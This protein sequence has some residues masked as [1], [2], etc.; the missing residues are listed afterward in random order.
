MSSTKEFTQK[1]RALNKTFNDQLKVL[2]TSYND[3]HKQ[4]LKDFTEFTKE[5]KK[6]TK[7]KRSGGNSNP[8][9]INKPVSVPKQLIPLCE[10][11]GH[12]NDINVDKDTVVARTT[13][14]GMIYRSLVNLAETKKAKRTKVTRTTKSGNERNYSVIVPKRTSSFYKILTYNG[15]DKDAVKLLK[16]G[17]A[18][19][20]ISKLISPFYKQNTKSKI[21]KVK[22][23]LIEDSDSDSDSSI[24]IS[25]DDEEDEENV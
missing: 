5:M 24:S 17:V 11:L 20:D 3:A 9:G 10:N 4:L 18:M 14:S 13:I 1:L 12:N 8:S 6:T 19:T 15:K 16:E 7:Q 25:S 2:K 23:E 22:E 21:K